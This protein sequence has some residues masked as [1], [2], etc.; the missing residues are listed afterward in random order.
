[1]EELKLG[2]IFETFPL[3]VKIVVEV[4]VGSETDSNRWLQRQEAEEEE[5]IRITR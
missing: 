2:V 3:A 4:E 5:G 1:M